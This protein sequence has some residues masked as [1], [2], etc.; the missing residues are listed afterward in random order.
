MKFND[1]QSEYLY[2]KEKIDSD[3][4]QVF[5][6]GNYLL[7]EKTKEFENKFAEFVGKKYAV[8]VGNA[9]DGITATI[10]YLI[11]KMGKDT[12]IICPNYSAIPTAI[13]IKNVTNNIH[14]AEIDDT[15]MIDF[16]KLPDIKNAILVLVNL[17]GSLGNVDEAKAYCKRNDCIL[18]E[19]SAQVCFK[20]C[21]TKSDYAVF[22]HYPTKSLGSM[23]DCGTVVTN[24]ADFAQFLL[25]YRFYGQEGAEVKF[26]GVNSRT[27]ELQAAILLAKLP[28]FELLNSVRIGIANRYKKIIKGQPI[29]SH[30][31][32]HQFVVQFN[33]REEVIIPELNRREI[34]F[35]IHYPFHLPDKEVLRGV[36]Y[37]EPWFTDIVD[38]RVSDK[39]ISLPVHPFM[40]ESEIVQVEDFLHSCKNYEL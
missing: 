28:T 19:D 15:F 1:L 5:E 17:F 18:V 31:V 37:S 33:K 29:L 2:F 23:G 3:T 39:V 7:G 35:M 38:Y 8:T 9:T 6:S 21:S 25:R 16:S 40:K 36:G 11:D 22:S 14:Y 30:S 34:P 32:Y 24:D 13:A 10:K 20:D 26:V 12:T 4:Q 27:S